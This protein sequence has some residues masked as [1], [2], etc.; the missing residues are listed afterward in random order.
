MKALSRISPLAS[1]RYRSYRFQWPSDLLGSWAYEMETLILGWFVLVET[2]SVFMLTVFGALRYVGTL[3]APFGGVIGD[4][5]GRRTVILFARAFFTVLA[6]AFMT[7][8]LMDLVTP[9]HA[10]AMAFLV[11]LARSSDIGMRNAL[12]GDTIPVDTLMNAIGLARMTQ[13]S[14]RIFGALAAGGLLSLVGIGWSYLFVAGFYLISCLLTLGISHI[15]PSR[16]SFDSAAGGETDSRPKPSHWRD[17]KEGLAYI[18]NSPTILAVMWLAFLMNATALSIADGLLPFVAREIYGTDEGG[19]SHLVA[20]CACGALIGSLMMAGSGRRGRPALLMFAAMI[21]WL[22]TLAIFAHLESK[23][24]GLIALFFIGMFYNV[25][26]ISLSVTL[27]GALDAPV[28]GRVMGVRAFAV[29]GLPL[30]VLG[31]GILIERIGFSGT[32]SLY[33]VVGILSTLFIG[34]RYRDALWR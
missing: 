1:F 21:L 29:Y 14:A 20:A 19:L 16:S 34:Y 32:V 8:A 11:G 7:L 12:I 31:A 22:I 10:F 27:L 2:N 23:I 5:V 15:H 24:A 6:F 26:M 4:R 17:L 18:W 30:G 28:R 13:D 9:Y 25:S 3:I 33:A